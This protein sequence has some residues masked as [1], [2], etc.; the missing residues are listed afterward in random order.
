LVQLISATRESDEVGRAIGESG[1][2][3]PGT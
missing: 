2:G 3:Y 1:H